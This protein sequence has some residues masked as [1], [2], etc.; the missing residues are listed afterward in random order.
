MS[1]NK[2]KVATSA[3]AIGLA[4][5]LLLGGTF[6]WQ[7]ISQTALNEA[8]NVVNPGGRLH[9]DFNGENKDVYV[10][11][12]ADDAIY[13]RIRLDEYFEIIQNKG[14][15]AETVNPIAG[16]KDADGNIETWQTHYFDS[17]NSTDEYWD[18]LTGGSTTYMP[19]FNK[20]KD[21]LA[22]DVNGT[23]NGL[24]GV[25]TDSESDDRYTDYVEYSDG[26][27]VT[28]DAIYD[29][30]ANDIEDEN[31]TNVSEDHTATS[32]LDATLMSMQEWIDAGSQPGE[33]WVYDTDGWVYWAQAIEPDT[34]TGLLL[35]GIELTQ[36]MDD[37]WYYAINVVAQFITADDLGRNDNTG[38]YAD[39]E[40]VTDDALALLEAIGVDTKKEIK[41]A[42]DLKEALASG[43]NIVLEDTIAATDSEAVVNVSAGFVWTEG[44]SL[45][46]GTI[47]DESNSYAG[48][49]INN[50]NN[51]PEAGDGANAAEIND[52]SINSNS[53]YAVYAQ[54]INAPVTLNNVTVEGENGGVYAE[55]SSETVTLNNCDVTAESNHD[56][57]WVNTAVAAANGAEVEINGGSYTGEYAA[58]VY[59]SGGTITIN[60]GY[61][62]GEL[63]TDAGSIV[64][65]GGTFTTDPTAYVADGYVATYDQETGVYTV[66]EEQM[67]LTVSVVEPENW[68]GALGRGESVTVKVDGEYT[69]DDLTWEDPEVIGAACNIT[70]EENADGSA[71]IT[72]ANR[73]CGGGGGTVTVSL[74]SN[75]NVYTT[76]DINCGV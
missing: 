54:P 63:R 52:T 3:T 23:Y 13:A 34:A 19:T 15:P 76:V 47:N 41:T 11:N 65:N 57:Y 31:V 45:T 59:S 69:A 56:T 22:A 18:W 27:V 73:I 5:L 12:F 35:D 38:F 75:P 70:V 68:D 25:V 39:G 58:Y 62:D 24:D 32:T 20:N 74:T 61:F 2:K 67:T 21:S 10:E 28:D 36:V 48:L 43:G 40:T 44:G 17:A 60:D 64:I 37:S 30:D 53:N 51:W 50:E 49:F 33:Y 6:A 14:T 4:A 26:D 72:H 16:S 55:Y 8:S 66:I 29:A 1:I 7:S 9:D 46:G 42:D 71:T